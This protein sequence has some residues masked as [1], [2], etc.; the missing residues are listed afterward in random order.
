[1]QGDAE[2]ELSAYE[3]ERRENIRKNNQRLVELG[4]DAPMPA[5]R[6]TARPAAR[7]PL[8]AQGALAADEST[9]LAAHDS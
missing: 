3:L 2:E 5:V 1:M 9:T 6:L 4:L 7:P 8:G